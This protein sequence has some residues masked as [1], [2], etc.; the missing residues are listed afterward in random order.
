M[1]AAAQ[2]PVVWNRINKLRQNLGRSCRKH[3]HR[4]KSDDTDFPTRFLERSCTRFQG[5]AIERDPHELNHNVNASKLGQLFGI[6]T[7]ERLFH[8]GSL[9]GPLNTRW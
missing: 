2:R 9:W 3:F 6:G 7:G 8:L 4:F 1:H 5:L